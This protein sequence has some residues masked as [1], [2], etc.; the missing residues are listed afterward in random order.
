MGSHSSAVVAFAGT[1][2]IR[3]F[4]FLGGGVLK[5]LLQKTISGTLCLIYSARVLSSLSVHNDVTFAS[6]SAV[7]AGLQL[8]LCCL[9]TT[10]KNH[11]NVL[12]DTPMSLSPPPAECS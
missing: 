12:P 8:R 5:R 9:T 2:G 6:E 4:L 10:E 7:P 1:L 3:T 11:I